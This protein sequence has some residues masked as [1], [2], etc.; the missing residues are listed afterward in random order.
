M[1][2]HQ[3]HKASWGCALTE[4]DHDHCLLVKKLKSEVLKVQ[5]QEDG[6][7]CRSIFGDES[8]DRNDLQRLDISFGAS[9]IF[10]NL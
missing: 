7:T 10:Q 8:D 3:Y 1:C 2:P 6:W 9:S 5:A 4:R